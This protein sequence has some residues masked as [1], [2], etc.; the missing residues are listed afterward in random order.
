LALKALPEKQ[1]EL[2]AQIK[3][4]EWSVRQAEQFVT[5]VKEGFA[6]SKVTRQRMQTETP[7]TKQLSKKLGGTPVHIRRTAKG[8]KLEIAFKSDDELEKILGSLG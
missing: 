7:A 3:R 6:E 2:L 5:S 8:G 1:A 4:H